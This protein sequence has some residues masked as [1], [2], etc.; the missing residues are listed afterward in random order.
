[1]PVLGDLPM[2]GQVF[3]NTHRKDNKRELLIFVTPK[4]VDGKSK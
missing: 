3:R 1:V 4:I 2:V